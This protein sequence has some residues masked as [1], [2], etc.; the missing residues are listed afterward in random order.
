MNIQRRD[1]WL[2]DAQGRALAGADVYYVLQPA[3]TGTIPPSPLATVYSDLSGTP[4]TN[5]QVTDGF[6]HSVAYLDD[7]ALYTIVWNHPLFGEPIVLP[8]QLIGG[9]TSGVGLTPFAGV[10]IGTIDGTNKVFTLANGASPLGVAPS[11]VTVWLNYPL[12][13]GVGYTLSG[14]TITFATAPQPANGG[15]PGDSIYAQ[16]LYAA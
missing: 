13:Q 8:D 3:N 16:G 4:A 5:P 1:D 14:D 12:V 2:T 15:T 6:G 11:Q 7:S 10:P 9:G